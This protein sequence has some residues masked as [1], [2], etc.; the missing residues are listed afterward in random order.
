MLDQKNGKVLKRKESAEGDSLGPPEGQPMRKKK[1][2]VGVLREKFYPAESGDQASFLQEL[3]NADSSNVT[4]REKVFRAHRNTIQVLFN[5]SEDGFSCVPGFFDHPVHCQLHFQYL[6]EMSLLQNVEDEL[7]ILMDQVKKVLHVWCRTEASR[8]RMEV[9]KTKS[10][11]LQGSKI[12]LYVALLREL[13]L[14]WHK[15]FGGLI[16]ITGEEESSGPHILCREGKCAMSFDIHVEKKK[17]LED[18][19]FTS[20]IASFFHIIFILQLKYPEEAEAVTILLQRKVAK[21]DEEGKNIRL[22]KSLNLGLGQ[23]L[24][25]SDT[26]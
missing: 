23:N 18:L 11:E 3:G 1:K 5:Q 12:P 22:F 16:R 2:L 10:L 20:A 17:V 21:V 15:N 9:A 8:Q 24:L 19:T 6:A 7:G 26:E 13:T 14:V 25:G 4:E